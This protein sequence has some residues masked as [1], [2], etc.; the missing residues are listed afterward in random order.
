MEACGYV[1]CCET[2]NAGTALR[3]ARN[4]VFCDSKPGGGRTIR[5]VQRIIKKDMS[6]IRRGCWEGRGVAELFHSQRGGGAGGGMFSH[7]EECWEERGE[8]EV[9]HSLGGK[10]GGDVQS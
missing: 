6:V 8:S 5:S 7:R 10:G 1:P 4:D 2:G 3:S 9:F